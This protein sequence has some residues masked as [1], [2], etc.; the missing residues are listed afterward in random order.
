[1]APSLIAGMMPVFAIAP[2]EL[3]AS[4]MLMPAGMRTVE[5]LFLRGSSRARSRPAWR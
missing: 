5:T 4:I 2:R 1:M 3:V